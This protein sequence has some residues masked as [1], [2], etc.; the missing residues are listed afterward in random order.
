MSKDHQP[1]VALI[2]CPDHRHPNTT[3]VETG[4]RIAVQDQDLIQETLLCWRC[5]ESDEDGILK[6]LMALNVPADEIVMV[7]NHAFSK[8]PY[9]PVCWS[10]I[11]R[12]RETASGRG[13]MTKRESRRCRGQPSTGQRST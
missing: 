7:R 4:P 13:A 1:I 5:W 3:I 6:L 10:L 8:K 2:A 9:T 12:Y 11:S